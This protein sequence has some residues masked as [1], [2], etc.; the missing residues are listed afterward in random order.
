MQRV[1]FLLE[2]IW[3]ASP[4]FSS[5]LIGL[6]SYYI[7][8]N[9]ITNEV[10]N[11]RVDAIED[12]FTTEYSQ[13][14]IWMGSF[15]LYVLAWFVAAGTSF[16]IISKNWLSVKALRENAFNFSTAISSVF[17]LFTFISWIVYS[18]DS[19]IYEE[20]I[21]SSIAYSQS[22]HFSKAKAWT[23]CLD[24]PGNIVVL[25]FIL[26]T[27][28]LLLPV[29][30]SIT[31]KS[32][33]IKIIARNLRLLRLALYT[34]TGLLVAN[35]IEYNSL[36]QWSLAFINVLD[37][38]EVGEIIAALIFSEGIYYSSFLAIIYVPSALILKKRAIEVI[39][40]GTPP[41]ELEIA[42][43]EK[44]I[45]APSPFEQ[46]KPLAAVLS[47]LLAGMSVDWMKLIGL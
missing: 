41:H 25:S 32:A 29:S 40:L 15:G 35:I 37:R 14:I 4:I 17:L 21:F 8:S 19:W 5:L 38:P 9:F 3:W 47:P 22:T 2:R 43:K 45:F 34:S 11:I 24:L 46:I 28:V 33:K 42:L 31:H 1:S 6:T 27:T 16:Y 30:P 12:D 10:I 20:P 36:M 26:A 44:G 23:A 7:E 13:R 39:P 18:S